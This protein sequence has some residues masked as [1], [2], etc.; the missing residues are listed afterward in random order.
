MQDRALE[1]RPC[2]G[3][4]ICVDR[5]VVAA[6][7][8]DQ[9]AL[10]QRG[11]VLDL[12]GRLF[13]KR[14]GFARDDAEAA[15]AAVATQEQHAPDRRQLL[16]VRVVQ[17]LDQVQNGTFAGALVGNRRDLVAG[18]DRAFRWNRTVD[19]KALLAVEQSDPI[20]LRK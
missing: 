3:R 5:I 12:R 2:G 13:G 6:Q 11:D 19:L 14:T 10:R 18:I 4:G 15:T 1:P 9:G 20:D 8:V 17:R 7:P 16:S